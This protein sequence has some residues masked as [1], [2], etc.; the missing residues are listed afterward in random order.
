MWKPKS[1]LDWR[2]GPGFA[3]PATD[4][5]SKCEQLKRI[6]KLQVSRAKVG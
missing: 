2:I 3:I 5:K 4:G 1:F 6:A